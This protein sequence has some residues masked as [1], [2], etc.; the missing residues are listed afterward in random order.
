M[1]QVQ[2]KYAERRISENY[3]R[4]RVDLSILP[5]RFGE[6]MRQSQH[7]NQW[8]A[9]TIDQEKQRVHKVL[10]NTL[11]RLGMQAYSVKPQLQAQMDKFYLSILIMI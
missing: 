2:G 11:L 10:D 8:S 4:R 5:I 6:F 1:K 7:E 9:E 3:R